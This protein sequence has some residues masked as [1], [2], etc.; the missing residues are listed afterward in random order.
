[1]TRPARGRCSR[2]STA[3]HPRAGCRPSWSPEGRCRVAS[4]WAC[5]PPFPRPAP[6]GRRRVVG[7]GQECVRPP[8][9]S[10]G[11]SGRVPSS[12]R[13]PRSGTPACQAGPWTRNEPS[14]AMGR[15]RSGD[16]EAAQASG[17]DRRQSGSRLPPHTVRMR[18]RQR[19]VVEGVH[20]QAGQ[21]AAIDEQE[22]PADG[23]AVRSDHRSLDWHG[24]A[25][26]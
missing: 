13:A 7:C 5:G 25:R 9:V 21:S 11:R 16:T 6:A 19:V 8:G 20:L 1:M 4:R 15:K 10:H 18:H 12:S 14:T 17:L 3:S 24:R 26:R 23:L 22:E 2:G